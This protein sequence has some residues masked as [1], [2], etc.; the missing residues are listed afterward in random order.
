M[1]PPKSDLLALVEKSFRNFNSVLPIFDQAAFMRTFQNLDINI[2][3]SDWWACLN[4]IL[5]LTNRFETTAT[6]DAA[7]D[8]EALEFFQNALAVGSRLITMRPTLSAVQALLGMSIVMLGTPNHDPVSLL[9]SSAIKLAQNMGLHR[10]YREP[11]LSKAEIEQRKRVFWIAYCLDKD[12]SLQTGQPPTQDEDDMDV[13]LPFVDIEALNDP[14]KQKN[15]DIFTFRIKLAIIQGQIY[16]QLCSVK[17]SKQSIAERVRAAKELNTVL[18][19]WRA[20]V[21][22]HFHSEDGTLSLPTTAASPSLPSIPLNLAYFNSLH[23]IN[24]SLS[25]LS[26]YHKVQG[27]QDPIKV[28]IMLPSINYADEARRAM[29]ILKI[30]PRRHYA[31]V[32]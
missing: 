5:A 18:Q 7:E 22:M 9:I 10:R 19:S 12:L 14:R 32:W 26:S 27:N 13:E 1:L 4:V 25:M 17:A 15:A 2:N 11:G 3:V 20:S 6:H 8:N 24:G 21:I 31:C 23:I 28:H 30:I 16:K 29:E